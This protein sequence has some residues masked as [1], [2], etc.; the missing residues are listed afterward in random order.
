MTYVVVVDVEGDR[1]LDHVT[2]RLLLP[3]VLLLLVEF[4]DPLAQHRV[5]ASFLLLKHLL[6]P[7]KE[8]FLSRG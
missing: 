8:Y 5:V 1:E 6:L 3:V 4:Q 7:F 2:G